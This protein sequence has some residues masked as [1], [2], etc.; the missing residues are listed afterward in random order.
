MSGESKTNSTIR[1]PDLLAQI[2]AKIGEIRAETGRLPSPTVGKPVRVVTQLIIDFQRKVDVE[3]VGTIS[4]NGLIQKMNAH[5]NVF[6]YQLRG[7][8]PR[9]IPFRLTEREE[10][11][12]VPEI[13][14][15]PEEE[16]DLCNDGTH[17]VLYLSDVESR[18]QESVC[19]S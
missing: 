16:Q 5:A 2:N 3:I 8:A 7:S 15:L 9:F 11:H 1:L 10:W 4:K 13:P 12:K 17:P 19:H 14:F 18:A 6:R